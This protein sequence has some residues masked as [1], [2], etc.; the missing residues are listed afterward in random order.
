[1]IIADAQ[2]QAYLLRG[3]YG[4]LEARACAYRSHRVYELENM[5][6]GDE[7]SCALGCPPLPGTVALGGVMVA[8]TDNVVPSNKYGDCY[9]GEWH[10]V[11]RNLLTGRVL[12]RVPTGGSKLTRGTSTYTGPEPGDYVGVGPALDVMVENNG[13][14]AWIVY[15]V[16]GVGMPRQYEVHVADHLGSHVVASSPDISPHSLALVG[17]TLYWTQGGK[18][19]SATLN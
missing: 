17:N 14:V 3:R 16:R 4:D 5:V 2:A 19:F 6:E 12:R 7:A 9:C 10:V 8:F 13:S 18:P 1:M 11:V 15:N